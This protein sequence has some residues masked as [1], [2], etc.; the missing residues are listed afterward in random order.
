MYRHSLISVTVLATIKIERKINTTNSALPVR[1]VCIVCTAS[2]MS[3]IEIDELTD[4]ERV[5]HAKHF[6]RYTLSFLNKTR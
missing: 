5:Y 1:P 3:S 4:I 2:R 6:A